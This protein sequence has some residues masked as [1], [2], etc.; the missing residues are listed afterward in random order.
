VGGALE[1]GLDLIIM[2]DIAG[3]DK[4]RSD[5]L[6]QRPDAALEYLA[7]VREGQSGALLMHRLS[8]S[9]GDRVI[10]GDAEDECG[11]AVK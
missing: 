1:E 3:L 11:L 6:R 2:G 4:R 10:V 7:G 9:P 5:G 8:D